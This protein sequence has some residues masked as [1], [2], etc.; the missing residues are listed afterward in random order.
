MTNVLYLHNQRDKHQDSIMASL[1]HR[2]KIAKANNDA[3]LVRLLEQERYQVAPKAPSDLVRSR[4][5][6]W[7]AITRYV[8]DVLFGGTALQV[9]EMVDGRDRWWVASN[10]QTGEIVYADSEAELR[11]WIEENYQ[12]Q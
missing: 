6:W 5:D 3:H 7:K 8:A 11:L 12:G 4:T 2:L 10:P 9:V 1:T